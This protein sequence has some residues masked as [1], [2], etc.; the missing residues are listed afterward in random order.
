M[1]CPRCK[2]ELEPDTKF[3]PNCKKLIVK[4]DAVQP[5]TGHKPIRTVDVTSSDNSSYTDVLKPHSSVRIKGVG[6]RMAGSPYVKA[7]RHKIT[8]SDESE[9]S[10]KIRCGNCRTENVKSN[11]FCKNCGTRLTS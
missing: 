4:D 6:S 10:Q 5:R 9:S 1:R 11:R 8:T 7:N 2:K 3:C